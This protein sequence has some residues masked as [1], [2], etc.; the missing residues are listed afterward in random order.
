VRI[1]RSL[2][3]EPR[4][5]A[6]ELFGVPQRALEQRVQVRGGWSCAT[7]SIVMLSVSAPFES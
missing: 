7:V 1:T 4:R 6:I 2:P 3:S 5:G